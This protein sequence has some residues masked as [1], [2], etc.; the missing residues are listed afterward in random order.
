MRRL[1]VL[2]ASL[3]PL[4]VF[5]ANDASAQGFGGRGFHGGGIRAGGGAFGGGHRFGL[6]GRS[7]GG[8]RAGLGGYGYRGGFYRG[9]AAWGYRPNRWY[10]G[11]GY[12][13]RRGYYGGGWGWGAGALAAGTVLGAAA[14]YPYYYGDSGYYDA[15]YYPRRQYYAEPYY[16]APMS[17][18]IGDY[19]QTPVRTCKL[20]NP[21]DLGAGCS[22]RV[23]GGRARGAVIP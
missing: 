12:Y 11:G 22:C 8:Y 7:F 2:A 21:S 4:F 14:A 5:A 19:C 16:A 3:V 20:I 18:G 9:G 17:S 6:G 10:G 15:P 1:I 23:A 13:G